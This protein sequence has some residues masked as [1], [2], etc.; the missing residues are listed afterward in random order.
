[1]LMLFFAIVVVSVVVVMV[2][3]GWLSALCSWLP[4]F[5][6]RATPSFMRLFYVFLFVFVLLRLYG[7]WSPF[8]SQDGS[9]DG[10]SGLGGKQSSRNARMDKMQRG[11]DYDLAGL[12]KK[13]VNIGVDD[14][15]RQLK[16]PL[17]DSQVPPPPPCP[18][19]P[20]I[21]LKRTPS[22]QTPMVVAKPPSQTHLRMCVSLCS[23]PRRLYV[24]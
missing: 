5:G 20:R 3:R 9:S 16:N 11:G 6:G 1:M 17:K 14:L 8:C 7:G 22:K 19:P 4:W 12:L 21:S 24:L 10:G 13:L 15:R 2:L 18:S 23:A